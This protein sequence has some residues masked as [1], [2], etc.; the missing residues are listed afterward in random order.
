M[1]EIKN[2]DQVS[3][4]IDVWLAQAVKEAEGA[5]RGL[6]IEAFEIA[7]EHSPQATGDFVANWELGVGVVKASNSTFDGSPHESNAQEED[8]FLNGDRPAMAMARVRNQGA[9]S[10]FKLGDTIYLSNA[11]AHDEPYALKIEGNQINFRAGNEGAV[12]E[13]TVSSLSKYRLIGKT[14]AKHLGRKKL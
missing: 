13:R 10:S 3:A 1:I 8:I 7:L 5:A 6:V 9:L 12:I 11:S 14:A 2:A 4:Q